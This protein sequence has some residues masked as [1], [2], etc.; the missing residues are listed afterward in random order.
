VLQDAPDRGLRGV[1]FTR[2]GQDSY[3]ALGPVTEWFGPDARFVYADDPYRDST[4]EKVLRSLYPLH[5]GQM[6]GPIGVALD[7]ILGLATLEMTGTGLYLWLKR[8]R[9][10][11]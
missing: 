6:I 11:R 3:R 5:T 7:I 2:S 10:R 4:G 8:R 9:L 1:R